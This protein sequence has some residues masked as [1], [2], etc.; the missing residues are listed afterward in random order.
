[1][2]SKAVERVLMH[3]W[4][5]DITYKGSDQHGYSACCPAHDDRDPSLKIDEGD[6]GRALVFCHAGCT[7]DEIAA[8]L[9]IPVA[10]LFEPDLDKPVKREVTERY[11]YVDEDGKLL[12]QVER[13]HPKGFRQRRPKGSGW[14]Y[15][16]GDVR[17]VIYRLPQVIA[18]VKAGKGIVIVEGER[19]VHTLEAK[20]QVAT[21]CPGGAGKWRDQYSE[22]LRGA[23][24]AVIQDMDPV[25]PKTGKRHGQEH[26][27]QVK[28]SLQAVGAKVTMLQPA[29]G[30]DVTDHIQAGLKLGA[31]VPAGEISKER[32]QL[33]SAPEVM[34]LPDPDQEGY[35]L[36]P[37]I[38][39]G[40]RI[41]IGGH[42][43][44]GKTT[45][46]MHMVACAVNGT[47]FLDSHWHGKGGLRALI[48][49]VEQGTKS[50]KR[51]LRETGL[52]RN[53]NVQYLRVPDGL[54]LD[55]DRDAIASVEKIFAEGRFDLVCADPLYKLHR[56]DPNDTRAATELMRRFDDW[57]ERYQFSLL[58]PMHCRKPSARQALSPHDLFGSSAYQWG[59]EIL[60]GLERPQSADDGAFSLFH[61]W[62]DRDG[63]VAETMPVN[64]KWGL[65]FDRAAG[66]RR[67]MKPKR[68]NSRDVIHDLLR[69]EARPVTAYELQDL[70][71]A[72]RAPKIGTI[73]SALE[74]IP[75]VTHDGRKGAME[76]RYQLPIE[77]F[78]G[79][80][81]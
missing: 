68:L 42:T 16:L 65:M 73:R 60:L 53:P 17:R 7:L 12:F 14:E 50:I 32:L 40:Y 2:P 62:K 21:T 23:K 22:V 36:G 58:L 72:E 34:R 67:A 75:G 74:S 4:A 55:T 41:V 64:S 43:G 54:A 26:A 38:Y 9:H 24:V 59:A 76:R 57:R 39:R 20:D 10:D 18:A 27:E 66:F 52:D 69:K 45:L 51:V 30:K 37:L 61:M 13:M 80:T 33:L 3:L 46:T 15:T 79:D 49:D 78:S 63:E 19:D 29:V 71:P 11:D 1:M 5:Q 48:V 35:L 6:D 31:L 81:A 44:H 47:D 28:R 70:W 77:M 56:G 8:G 25:D